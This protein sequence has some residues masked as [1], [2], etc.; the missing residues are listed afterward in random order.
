M[1][2]SNPESLVPT[3]EKWRKAEEPEP[4]TESYKI[5]HQ[6]GKGHASTPGTMAQVNIVLS[7]I[8]SA[9]SCT[10][11]KYRDANKAFRICLGLE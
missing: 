4:R 3:V 5:S 1:P 9:E 2:L 11:N 7:S 10:E 6:R 8:V